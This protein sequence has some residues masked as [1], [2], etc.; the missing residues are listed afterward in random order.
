M[1]LTPA[2]A[3]PA[4]FH[5]PLYKYTRLTPAAENEVDR[6]DSASSAAGATEILRNVKTSTNCNAARCNVKNLNRRQPAHDA[7]LPVGNPG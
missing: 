2:P 4:R 5:L 7:P 3:A 6:N 1:L